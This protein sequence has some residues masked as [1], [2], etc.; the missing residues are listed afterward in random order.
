MFRKAERKKAKLRLALCG[1]AGSGKTYSAL[2]IAQGLG[3]KIAMIDTEHGSGELY[4][5][6]Y[7]YDVAPLNPPF[8]PERYIQ[9]I[10]EAERA[11]YDVL[12]IDSLSHAWSGEGGVLDMK[13]AATR[14]SKSGNSFAAW[15]E[16][17]PEHNRLVETMLRTNLHLIVN[18]RTKTAWEV[19]EEDGKKRPVKVGLAPLQ[20]EGL[21]YEFTVVLDL[22]VEGHIATA[23]KDR[24]S[25]FDGKHF[26]PNQNTGE[27]LLEWLEA[28]QDIQELSEAAL[29]AYLERLATI[30]DI[31][32]LKAWWNENKIEIDNNLLSDNRKTLVDAVNLKKAAL[33]N[34]TKEVTA[35]K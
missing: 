2:L 23:T 20:R 7:D 4:A 19:V 5:H 27:E 26:L 21:E 1:P 22:S 13:D 8:T 3:G 31:S 35:T 24:T 16:V 6:L 14:A 15:R 18:M 28:G 29:Q 33:G 32:D 34:G 12:I 25:L 10:Y 17:T 9:V 11:G 30:E